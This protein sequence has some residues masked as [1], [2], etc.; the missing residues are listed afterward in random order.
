MKS[1]K[2]DK[3]K[4]KEKDKSGQAEKEG[5]ESSGLKTA[6]AEGEITAGLSIIIIRYFM[7]YQ[8]FQC[9]VELLFFV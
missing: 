3:D 7:H 6:G 9:F 1:L 4:E 8:S 5:P 2:E